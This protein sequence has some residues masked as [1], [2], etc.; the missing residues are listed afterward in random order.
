M[1]KLKSNENAP[2]GKL[3]LQ[4]GLIVLNIMPHDQIVTEIV[5]ANI[6]P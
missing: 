6:T 2:L 5:S 3:V 1:K 4:I